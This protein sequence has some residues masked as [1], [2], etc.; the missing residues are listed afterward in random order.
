MVPPLTFS[1]DTLSCN[2]DETHLTYVRRAYTKEDKG[3]IV[4]K[5]ST[6]DV[7]QLAKALIHQVAASQ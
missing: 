6:K 5:E 4:K 3:E 1:R 2:L 7:E